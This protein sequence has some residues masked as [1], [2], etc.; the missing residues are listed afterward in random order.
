[1]VENMLE[2]AGEIDHDTLVETC[3]VAGG[4]RVLQ[5]AQD[6]G[7]SSPYNTA[8]VSPEDGAIVEALCQAWQAMREGQ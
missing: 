8:A 2:M 7:F 1:M 4:E 5:I 6:L 3:L